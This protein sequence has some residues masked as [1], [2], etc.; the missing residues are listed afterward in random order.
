MSTFS[1]N[2]SINK[3]TKISTDHIERKITGIKNNKPYQFL[4]VY[5]ATY[6]CERPL[7]AMHALELE[8]KAE[9]GYMPQMFEEYIN[10]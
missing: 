5:K 2:I 1:R 8:R 9:I 3:E 7:N 6:E 4:K 10:K